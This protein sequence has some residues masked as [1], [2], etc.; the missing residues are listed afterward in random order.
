MTDFYLYL[1][2]AT[3]YGLFGAVLS[4]SYYVCP[5]FRDEPL[6]HVVTA[7][8]VLVAVAL[9][10][11]GASHISAETRHFTV[12]QLSTQ[13]FLFFGASLS[14]VPIIVF[15]AVHYALVILERITSPGSRRG[16]LPQPMTPKEDWRLIQALL[17]ALSQEPTSPILH[18]R[19]GDVYARLGFFDSAAYQY[20]KAAD[21]LE[22]GYAHGHVLYKSAFL[23]VEKKGDV[24]KALVILRRIVRLYPKSCFAAYSRRILNSYEARMGLEARE[25]RS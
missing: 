4:A 19:L 8:L 24:T 20:G 6:Y 17:N 10:A 25:E 22:S 12:F 11:V 21:W 18:E 5:R 23:L 3:A 2:L 13:F 15:L 1:T 9:T 16:R 14:Y 7:A